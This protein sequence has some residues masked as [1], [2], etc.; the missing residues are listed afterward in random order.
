[1]FGKLLKYELKSVSKWYLGLYVISLML[2]VVVGLWYHN[3][4]ENTVSSYDSAYLFGQI[5]SSGGH[6]GFMAIL[7][8]LLMMSYGVVM[9]TIV[10]STI[11]LIIKRFKDN[12]F[13]KQG[14]LTM[15]LPASIHHILGSKLLSSL[16]LS[17]LSL[18]IIVVSFALLGGI[19]FFSNITD[20]F[21]AL[22]NS[23]SLWFRDF[24]YL[25]LDFVVSIVQLSTFIMMVYL[26]MTLGH[27][28]ENH[29]T[30]LSFV[31]FF[32]VSVLYF[33]LYELLMPAYSD[34]YA[35]DNIGR[36]WYAGFNLVFHLI[37][38]VASYFATGYLLKH[39]LNLD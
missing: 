28:F 32:G 26:A 30:L 16:M 31:S 5:L 33:M 21:I 15:T 11:F 22:W 1:M 6:Q 2:S 34:Y 24:G 14:Y 19:H 10:L 25:A 7:L 13:G 35:F 4:V 17:L 18:V 8:M 36:Y 38:L 27:S 3:M 37:F 29:R 20:P 23:L 9:M 12:I 39:R